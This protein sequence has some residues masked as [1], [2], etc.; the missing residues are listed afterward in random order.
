MGEPVTGNPL[1]DDV[2]L[3]GDLLGRTIRAQAGAATF[4]LVERIRRTSL[5][6]RREQEREARSELEGILAELDDVEFCRLHSQD[7][8]RHKLVGQIVDAYAKFDAETAAAAQ[9]SDRRP[10]RTRR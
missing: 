2:R 1:R 7:V 5:R 10:R 3:L 8:V 6:F 9:L 4:D